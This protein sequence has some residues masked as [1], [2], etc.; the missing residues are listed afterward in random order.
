MF[1]GGVYS[2]NYDGSDIAVFE[3]FIGRICVQKTPTYLLAQ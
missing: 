1:V 2:N 3:M